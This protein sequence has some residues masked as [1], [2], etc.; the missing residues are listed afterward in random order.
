MAIIAMSQTGAL[1]ESKSERSF[2]HDRTIPAVAIGLVAL[3]TVFGYTAAVVVSTLVLL[4]LMFEWSCLAIS[5]L[6]KKSWTWA[7]KIPRAVDLVL[8]AVWVPA[9][10][11]VAR[12]GGPKIMVLVFGCSFV[13]DIGGLAIGKGMK[14]RL[15]GDRRL[16]RFS[17]N[18]TWEGV[19]GGLIV[20]LL[21]TVGDKVFRM[22][23]PWWMLLVTTVAVTAIGVISDVTESIFKRSV[24]ADDSG[25]FLRDHGGFLDRCDALMAVTL[26]YALLLH[27]SWF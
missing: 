12:H 9:F 16:S 5:P 2:M 25:T 20:A 17:P 3:A 4:P 7:W 8:I 26:C 11:Y 10:I 22:D 6:V 15:F 24:G 14:G 19:L 1:V 23:I 21:I 27:Q 18:K 13:A